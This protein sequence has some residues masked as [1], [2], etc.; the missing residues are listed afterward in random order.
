MGIMLHDGGVE[1]SLEDLRQNEVRIPEPSKRHQPI[2]HTVFRDIVLTEVANR[3]LVVKDEVLGLDKDGARY[4]GFVTLE[5]DS[6]P[7]RSGI[8]LGQEDWSLCLGMRNSWDQSFRAT[9]AAGEHVFVCDNLSISGEVVVGHKNTAGALSKLPGRVFG[10]LAEILDT[11][12]STQRRIELFQRTAIDENFVDG[13]L[14]SMLRDKAMP[15]S[16]FQSILDEYENPTYEEHGRGTA[17]T[18][19][20]AVT[21]VL[22][23]T[24]P[25]TLIKRTSA[26]HQTLEAQILGAVSA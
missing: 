24:A 14:M 11:V 1:V 5:P 23:G 13:A 2:S 25:Q 6:I 16:K 12:E 4:F 19:F 7:A 3:G 8:G 18:L 22:K 21:E 10:G 26:L 17:W 9:L 20:N 15:G